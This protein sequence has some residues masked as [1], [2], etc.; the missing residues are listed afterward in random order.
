MKLTIFTLLGVLVCGEVRAEFRAGVAKVVITPPVGVNMAGYY[1]YRACEG[2][3][4][5]IHARALV[6]DDGATRV[7]LV[8]L[9]LIGT[10]RE[11]VEAVRAEVEKTGVMAGGHVMISATHAHTGPV[12]GR[13]L[14]TPDGPE[15][16]M[17]AEDS[18]HAK[19]MATLPGL[20]A[21]SVK[22]AA[23]K[24]QPVVLTGVSGECPDVSFCRR[25]FMRD[26]TVGWNPGKLNPKIV[27]ATAVPDERVQAIFFQPPHAPAQHVPAMAVYANFSMHP[28]TVGG[29]KVS[30]DYPAALERVLAGYHGPECVTLYGNG[31]CGNLNHLDVAWGRQQQG[32]AEANRIG[33]LLGASIFRAEKQ[34]RALAAGELRVKSVTVPLEVPVVSKE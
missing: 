14:R 16:G 13:F 25:F 18:V 34:G 4:D 28:D 30:G 27:V 22:E 20:I 33:T 23:E 32:I 17:P 5:D 9:D 1:N 26:G 21:G 12:P 8:T 29:A 31:T 6:L 2:V 3:L 15:S 11:L 10:P 24:L 7:G 19:Y